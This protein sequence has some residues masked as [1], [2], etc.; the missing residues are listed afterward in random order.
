MCLI[1]FVLL[2]FILKK[3][4]GQEPLDQ[5]SS[6]TKTPKVEELDLSSHE[7]SA[8]K[9]VSVTTIIF[10]KKLTP[11]IAK[12][13]ENM[14]V[15]PLCIQIVLAL[16]FTGAKEAT[17]TEL[18]TLLSLPKIA[19]ETTLLGLKGLIRVVRD[20]VLNLANLMFV[21]LSA[22][23]KEEFQ[24]VAGEYFF[25][26]VESLDFKNSPEESRKLINSWVEGETHH[27][28]GRKHHHKGE[29]H[30]HEGET[31][32]HEGE[33][34]HHN[35]NHI[36]NL[37]PSGAISGDTR[38]V[39]V[40]TIHFFAK[41]KT[42]FDE[43]STKK[44][45][46]YLSSTETVQVSMLNKKSTFQFLH[47]SEL[48]VKILRL[49][50]EGEKFEMV[51]FLPQTLELSHL[52]SK[53]DAV[54]DRTTKTKSTMVDVYLPKFKMEIT[55]ELKNVLTSIGVPTMFSESADFS[56]ISDDKLP[57]SS[58]VQKAFFAVDEEDTDGAADTPEVLRSQRR[59]RTV[60][61]DHETFTADRPFIFLVALNEHKIPI[62]FGRYV[63]P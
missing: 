53:I 47:D 60:D 19:D 20:P 15:C 7:I 29:T 31:H 48:G 10:V 57:V 8:L 9:N 36:K 18:A 1:K 34:H 40:N 45:Q 27:D 22:P 49:D 35:H 28:D 4:S 44:Q 42:K 3:S 59:L 55:M 56:G 33:T 58:I 21:E 16:V 6:R 41:W 50:Y 12:N 13:G 62:F 11:L 38:L 23:V 51:L 26:S 2:V 32:H 43:S 63:R 14:I 52:E 39:L 17:A 61:D 25:S 30:H 54:F 46:F 37:L 24:K 5:L